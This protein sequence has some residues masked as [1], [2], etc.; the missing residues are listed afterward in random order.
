[1]KLKDDYSNESI[2]DNVKKIYEKN[3]IIRDKNKLVQ[4]VDPIY[5]DPEYNGLLD[6]RTHF[7][8]PRKQFMGHFFGTFGFNLAVILLMTIIL[9]FTLYYQV[10]YKLLNLPQKIGVKKLKFLKKQ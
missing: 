8:A 2:Q 1:R 6:F 7:Y 4:H 5:Q 3:K 9:Y 10:L